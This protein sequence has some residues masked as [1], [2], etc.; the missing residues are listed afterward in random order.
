MKAVE[1]LHPVVGVKAA[2]KPWLSRLQA[3]I[4]RFGPSQS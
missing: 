1:E 3:G 2:C 4:D